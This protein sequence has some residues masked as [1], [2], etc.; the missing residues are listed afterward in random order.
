M[1]FWLFDIHSNMEDGVET[2]HLYGFN[3]VG[4][5][6]ELFDG[7]IK[8]FLFTEFRALEFCK[9]K[10]VRKI[11]GLENMLLLKIDGTD[12]SVDI[13]KMVTL[14][15]KNDVDTY[16]SDKYFTG[17]FMEERGFT[18]CMWHEIFGAEEIAPGLYDLDHAIITKLPDDYSLPPISALA[19]DI[20]VY[21]PKGKVDVTRDPIILAGLLYRN[22]LGERTSAMIQAKGHYDDVLLED[23]I[24]AIKEFNPTFIATY[25]GNDFDWSYIAGRS[26]FDGVKMRI[27]LDSSQPHQTEFQ[28]VAIHGRP[29]VDVYGIAKFVVPKGSRKTQPVVHRELQ[30]AELAPQTTK[31]YEI[32]RE[33]IWKLWD[34]PKTREEVV[35]HCNGD[36]EMTMDIFDY[37]MGFAIELC[38][39]T[40]LPPDEVLSVPYSILVEGFIMQVAKQLNMVVPRNEYREQP[41]TSGAVNVE[42]KKGVLED[43]CVFDFAKMYPNILIDNNISPETYVEHPDMDHLELYHVIESDTGENFY[44]LKEPKGLFRVA[45]EILLKKIDEAKNRYKDR[46]YKQK[47]AGEVQ[48][49][50]TVARSMYGYL[51]APKSRWFHPKCQDA[52]ASEGRNRVTKAIIV[53]ENYGHE[54]NYADTDSLFLTGLKRDEV[55]EFAAV[56]SEAVGSTVDFDKWYSLIFF[57]EAKKIYAGLTEKGDLD[58]VGFTKSDW[59]G[60]ANRA[61]RK[62]LE[63]ILKERDPEKARTY[64][65]ELE[66][67]MRAGL[68]P[69]SDFIIWKKIGHPLE[70]YPQ[71]GAIIEV[72]GKKRRVSPPAH[73]VVARRN[74]DSFVEEDGTVGYVVVPGPKKARL[75]EVARSYKEVKSIKEL[76]MDYYAKNQLGAVAERILKYF[77]GEKSVKKYSTI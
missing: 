6:V 1:K 56:L 10:A 19:L 57:T 36:I 65:G 73:V 14:L 55:E 49:L 2:A 72:R 16:N 18:P 27:A 51:K 26:Q 48:A 52:T 13:P 3:E 41:E 75:Y 58:L 44:F 12:A 32:D 43:I 67:A 74:P 24:I 50:K 71:I 76:D 61:Q 29:T 4:K 38:R 37:A 25:N 66:S 21:N 59:V 17:V 8:P 64:A 42:P 47:Y 20:E 40:N 77:F 39:L 45:M 69:M 23:V 46:K 33:L 30:R 54:V 9:G 11:I 53:A 70:E 31:Y 28:T 60:I 15:K 22:H 35:K 5:V 7:T 68:Y 34:D 63:I 62:I